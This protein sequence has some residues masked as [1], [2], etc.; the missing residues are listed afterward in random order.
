LYL[1]A[2]GDEGRDGRRPGGGLVLLELEVVLV[3]DSDCAKGKAG[4]MDGRKVVSS[5]LA[6]SGGRGF[7]C[8]KR[9][10]CWGSPADE[11]VGL[12]VELTEAGEGSQKARE[13]RRLRKTYLRADACRTCKSEDTE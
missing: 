11:V 9:G 6:L 13:L 8:W 1:L 3:T 10:V 2:L 7:D 12:L 4:R 5:A